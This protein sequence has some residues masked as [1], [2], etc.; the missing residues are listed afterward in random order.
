MAGAWGSMCHSSRWEG[1][2]G[3]R[4]WCLG[5]LPMALLLRLRLRGW[6]GR[7]A[8]GVMLGWMILTGCDCV[9]DDVYVGKARGLVDVVSAV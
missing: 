6:V 4:R 3:I 2:L 7:Q 9:S 8:L 5:C 1:L